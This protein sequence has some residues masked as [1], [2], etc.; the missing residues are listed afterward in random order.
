[1][2]TDLDIKN[3]V[4]GQIVRVELTDGRLYVGILFGITQ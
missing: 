4:M 3:D 2:A 1:M